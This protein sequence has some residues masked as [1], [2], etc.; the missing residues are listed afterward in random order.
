[1]TATVHCPPCG[2]PGATVETVAEAVFLAETHDDLHKHQQ[3]SMVVTVPRR[4]GPPK[5]VRPAKGGKR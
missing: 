4:L 1:M 5:Q 2:L 3:P